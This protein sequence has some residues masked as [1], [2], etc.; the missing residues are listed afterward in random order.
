[1]KE[2]R[3]LTNTEN[4]D[5]NFCSKFKHGSTTIY[6]IIVGYDKRKMSS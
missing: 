6:G 2:I 4:A 1:M 5:K 3:L